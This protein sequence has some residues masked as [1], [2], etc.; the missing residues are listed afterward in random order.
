[1]VGRCATGAAEVGYR[2]TID[3]GHWRRGSGAAMAN[4][5]PELRFEVLGPLRGWRAGTELDLGWPKQQTVL[6]RT[7]VT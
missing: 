6:E 5:V 7:R 4:T 1:M 2:S 3:D